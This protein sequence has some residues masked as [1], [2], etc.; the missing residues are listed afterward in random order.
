MCT[1]QM[2]T[3]LDESSALD[4]NQAR[5]FGLRSTKRLS[6]SIQFTLDPRPLPAIRP[7]RF[8]LALQ[9]KPP[10]SAQVVAGGGI[11]RFTAPGARDDQTTTPA[12]I[13]A[14]RQPHRPGHPRRNGST[15][16]PR[17]CLMPPAAVAAHRRSRMP[18]R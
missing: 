9:V 11:S 6:Y 12:N 8:R 4:H 1:P 5:L 17:H 2:Y 3:V 14:H 10:L 18:L 15:G 16:A 7:R 13:S